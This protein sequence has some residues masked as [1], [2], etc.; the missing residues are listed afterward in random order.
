[1]LIFFPLC[2]GGARGWEIALKTVSCTQQSVKFLYM[3]LFVWQE[4]TGLPLPGSLALFD[5]LTEET[6]VRTWARVP[7]APLGKGIFIYSEI[8]E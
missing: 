3:Q 8:R 1:M 4:I 7:K 5:L 2:F 6:Q